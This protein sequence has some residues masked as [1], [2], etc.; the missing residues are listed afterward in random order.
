MSMPRVPHWIVLG[1]APRGVD[2]QRHPLVEEAEPRAR[3]DRRLNVAVPDVVGDERADQ[4]VLRSLGIDDVRR[5]AGAAVVGSGAHVGAARRLDVDVR[6]RG[7]PAG[8]RPTRTLT[9]GAHPPAPRDYTRPDGPARHRAPRLAGRTASRSH[10]SVRAGPVA[11]ARS[12]RWPGS[13]GPRRSRTPGGA[14]PAR[15][16]QHPGRPVGG[17]LAGEGATAP[18][19]RSANKKPAGRRVFLDLNNKGRTKSRKAYLILPSL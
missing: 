8:G 2:R 19:T 4:R 18:L 9:A 5:P 1:P 3:D 7:R 16:H 14:G 6:D 15:R 13:A 12:P 17:R 10:P 11:P